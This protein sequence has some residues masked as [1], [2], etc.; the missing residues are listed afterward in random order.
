MAERI[1]IVDD[2]VDMLELLKRIIEDKTNY[3]VVITPDPLGVPRILEENAFDLVIT[4]LRMPGQSGLELLETIRK[5]DEQIPIIILTAYGTIE[6]AV[7]AMQKGAFS[8]ITKPFKKEEI[9]LTIDNA[10]NFQRLKNENLYLRK[11]LEDKLKFPFL[12]GASPLMEKVYQRIMQ[13]ARTSATILITG[14]SGTGKELAAKTIHFHS[15]RKDRN[16]VAVNCSAIPET[17]IESELFGHLKGSFTGAIRDKKGLVEEADRGTLFLDEIGDLNLVMQTKLLRLL[18]EGEYKPVGSSKTLIADIRFIAATNQDLM[19]KVY[20]KEFRED[21]FYRL[22]VIQIVL[23]P[24]RDRKD[25]IPILAQHFLEKYNK[26]NQKGIK[27]IS[28]EA[29]EVL[30]TRVWP[31][32]IRELE[33]VI[34]RGVILSRTD[35]LQVADLFPEDLPNSFPFRI[36]ENIFMSPFKEAKEHIINNF[37]IEYIRRVLA[38]HGGN[39][40]LAAKECGLKRPYLHRLMREND[41]QSKNYRQSN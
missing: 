19:E 34:E 15:Q 26:L 13:V 17:L 37:H 8:Y 41:I 36:Q 33:N 2:E 10:F 39:V 14:E 23:P 3:Q 32:N 35:L 29:L 38:K 12:I 40:S 24:L 16:I 25:D 11:E 5:K 31:G 9:L 7:E 1:L 4:D 27:G 18:Q 22:N 21:L 6:S 28:P 30:M 20:K